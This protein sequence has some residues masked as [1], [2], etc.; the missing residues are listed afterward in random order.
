MLNIISIM[1]YLYTCVFEYFS[2]VRGFL[3]NISKRISFMLGDYLFVSSMSGFVWIEEFS[4][5]G[6][7]RHCCIECYRWCFFQSIFLYNC[8]MNCTDFFHTI[9]CHSFILCKKIFCLNRCHYSVIKRLF[10]KC[11]VGSKSDKE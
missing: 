4:M 6:L 1:C 9:G 5:V 10:A 11:L 7:G 2:D 3:A 8:A